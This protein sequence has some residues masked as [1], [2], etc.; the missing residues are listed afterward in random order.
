MYFS[1]DTFTTAVVTAGYYGFGNSLDE[2]TKNCQAAGGDLAL[3]TQG[4]VEFMF[5]TP[6]R[7]D[8]TPVIGEL[9]WCTADGTTPP[10]PVVTE[11]LR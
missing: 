7:L 3:K 11:K 1:N 10:R 4:H 5:D 9:H 2:A 6:V 8:V